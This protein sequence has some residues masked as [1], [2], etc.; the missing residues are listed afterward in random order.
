MVIAGLSGA[1]TRAAASA[2]RSIPNCLPET[3]IG[4]HSPV[5]WTVIEA[6]VVMPRL[7]TSA[8]IPRTVNYRILD[9]TQVWE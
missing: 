1:A 9:G 5:Q 8:Q 7:R 6:D 4:E 2:V 3:P